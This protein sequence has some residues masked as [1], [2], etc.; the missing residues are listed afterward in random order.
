MRS[1]WLRLRAAIR[2]LNS[3]Y[4]ALV[5][6]TGIMSK[7]LRLDGAARLSGLLLGAGIVAYVLL[8]VAYAW[9]LAGYPRLLGCRCRALP[10]YRG[11]GGGRAL[12]YPVRLAEFTPPYW[13]FIGATAI[14]VLAGAQILELPPDPLSTSAR[15]VVAGLSVVL[16]AFGTWLIPAAAAGGRGVAPPAAPGAAGLRAGVVEHRL[17]GRHVQGSEP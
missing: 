13:V 10:A 11:S 6:A 1:W 12:A 17:P 7:A 15:D 14:S 5:M 16:W 3:G 9:R 8:A 2:D 4:F